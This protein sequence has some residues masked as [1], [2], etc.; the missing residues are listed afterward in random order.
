MLRYGYIVTQLNVLTDDWRAFEYLCYDAV[1]HMAGR[2]HLPQCYD[3]DLYKSVNC[4]MP[5]VIATMTKLQGVKTYIYFSTMGAYDANNS[6]KGC[7]VDDKTLVLDEV[8]QCEGK[9][10]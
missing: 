3:W 9:L 8:T 1:I 2:A 7:V 4:Y 10:S 5:V 6:L